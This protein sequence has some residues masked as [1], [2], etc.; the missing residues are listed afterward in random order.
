M[1]LRFT[2]LIL[3]FITSVLKATLCE[4]L[5]TQRDVFVIPH[6]V[7]AHVL[8]VTFTKVAHHL[9]RNSLEKWF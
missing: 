3:T 1:Q 2:A 9:R 5:R 4:S 7:Q 8:G 6:A